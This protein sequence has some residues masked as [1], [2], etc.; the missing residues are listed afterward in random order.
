MPFRRPSLIDLIRRARAELGPQVLR[1][2]VE[3][4]LARVLPGAV[5]GLHGHIAW[6]GRQVL[7]DKV[8]GIQL[9]RWARMFSKTRIEASES[10]GIA[11]FAVDEGTVADPA[12]PIG[13]RA[14]DDRGYTYVVT[15]YQP[16]DYGAGFRTVTFEAEATGAAQNLDG[17]EPIHLLTPLTGVT[18]PGAAFGDLFTEIPPFK[19]TGGAD[20]EEDRELR[21]RLLDR[22]AQE[23]LGGAPGHYVTLAL[24]GGALLAWERPEES[25]DG[26]VAVYLAD[27]TGPVAGV[28]PGGALAGVI[29]SQVAPIQAYLDEHAPITVDVTASSVATANR[30]LSVAITPDNADV[31]EQ[32][33][34]ELRAMFVREAIAQGPGNTIPV[35]RIQEAISLAEGLE[36]HV[37]S[38]P[39]SAWTAAAGTV[40]AS[41]TI[42]W[43]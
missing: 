15:E 22:M 20:R 13:H 30:S 16:V 3:A 25:G 26:T 12:I 31:R 4:V 34:L 1:R 2:S 11:L 9:V 6:F 19:W 18:S 14:R 5:H 27:I 10:S 8:S 28:D 29:T 36:S 17:E 24:R 39:S 35:S 43:L 7:P 32:V 37:L 38:I 33:E 23:A 40:L 21:T 41:A 42:T